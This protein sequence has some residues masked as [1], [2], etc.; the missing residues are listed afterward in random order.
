MRFKRLVLFVLFVAALSVGCTKSETGGNDE[1][2]SLIRTSYSVGEVT[3]EW[4][5]TTTEEYDGF[6]VHR[7]EADVLNFVLV[8]ESS[9]TENTYID[10][11]I[12]LGQTYYY[13][14]SV[15]SDNVE[16]ATSAI[17]GVFAA[18]S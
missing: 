15:V 11:D 14:V 4:D 7:S 5:Y 1:R 10:T 8:T 9:I 16:I 13:K 2:P 6:F 18:N 3:L 17:M 12:T